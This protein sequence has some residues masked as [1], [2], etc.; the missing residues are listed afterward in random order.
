MVQVHP[1]P[2]FVSSRF[3]GVVPKTSTHNPAHI[4]LHHLRIHSQRRQIVPLRRLC[5]IAV[6]LRV[7]IE[8]RLNLRVTKDSLNGPGFDFRLGK[9]GEKNLVLLRFSRARLGEPGHRVS[10]KDRSF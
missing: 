9:K 8:R 1:G 6:V 5:F 10:A 4:S 3:P 2:P 7:Q